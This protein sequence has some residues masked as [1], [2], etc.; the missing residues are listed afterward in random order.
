MSEQIE[1]AATI[2]VARAC[3]FAGLGIFCFMVGTA[4]FIV[5]SF[6][7]GGILTLLVCFVLLFK[8][9]GARR[10][11]YKRT[12]TWLMLAPPDRPTGAT[13]QQLIGGTLQTIYLTYAQYT[14]GLAGVLLSIAMVLGL[15][16]AQRYMPEVWQG[17][18][19]M[20]RPDALRQSPGTGF[21]RQPNTPPTL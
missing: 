21:Y 10:R 19:E 5:L 1:R 14:A 12:E 11:P 18:A 16:D 15:F 9:A 4:P 3:G 13:A 20:H 6:K 17:Q 7:V 8:G 2:S